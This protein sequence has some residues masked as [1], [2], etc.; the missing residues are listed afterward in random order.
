MYVGVDGTDMESVASVDGLPADQ[1]IAYHITNQQNRDSIRTSGINPELASNDWDRV[2]QFLETVADR[3]TITTRPDSRA[4]CVFAYPRYTDAV[5]HDHH[6]DMVFAID[7]TR[8][9]APMYRASYHTAT[10]VYEILEEKQSATVNDIIEMTALDANAQQAYE[11]AL[12]YWDSLE[13][14]S[15]PIKRGGELLIDGHVPTDAI[16][17]YTA[18]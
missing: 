6:E 7:L 2:N 10:E 16:T 1:T 12:A 14:T 18:Y 13:Q 9:D 15:P 17:H 5:D 3:E 11:K 4:E 8:V